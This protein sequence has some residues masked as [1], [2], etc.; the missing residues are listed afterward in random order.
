MNYYQEKQHNAWLIEQL[1]TFKKSE[2]FL[3]SEAFKV[4]GQEALLW[5]RPDGLVLS[6]DHTEKFEN[7]VTPF[8]DW[9]K[10]NYSPVEELKYNIWVEDQKAS[11]KKTPEYK[12]SKLVENIKIGGPLERDGKIEDGIEIYENG[13]V[14]LAFGDGEK[15]ENAVTPFSEF[16]MYNHYEVKKRQEYVN[17][18]VAIFKKSETFLKSEA[19]KTEGQQAFVWATTSGNVISGATEP[20]EKF[21][22]AIMP[23]EDWKK[24]NC[25]ETEE[26]AYNTMI[27]ERRKNFPDKIFLKEEKEIEQVESEECCM[28]M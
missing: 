6:N 20:G 16:E 1:A 25:S 5:L 7:A 17:E 14:E 22:N 15:F 9:K 8:D 12:N 18:Q 3:Q 24:D 26:L 28:S 2:S 21:E 19:F 23:W 4:D 13:T 27:E 11:F 10:T